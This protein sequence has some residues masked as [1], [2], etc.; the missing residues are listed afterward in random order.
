MNY[1]GHYQK[2]DLIKAFLAARISFA[3]VRF[4]D[5]ELGVI[6][7]VDQRRPEWSWA[8]DNAQY[9]K[10]RQELIDSFQYTRP[11]YYIGISPEME[12]VVGRRRF[13]SYQ[14]L[15]GH[16]TRNC[17]TANL[18]VNQNYILFRTQILPLFNTYEVSV[19][20]QDSARIDRLPF[21]VAAHFA[22]HEDAWLHDAHIRHDLLE[23]ASAR[24]GCLYLFMVGPFSNILIHKLYKAN[25]YNTYID[26]GSPLDPFLF[27]K[28]TRGYLEIYNKIMGWQPGAP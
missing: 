11:L 26:V 1:D 24:N 14:A 7:G 19:V 23:H 21:S 3:F 5:G 22:C 16:K 2:I 27:G 25:P 4:G 20:C 28:N 15:S 9:H 6:D 18:F 8:A 12:A 13:A 17:L 10:L